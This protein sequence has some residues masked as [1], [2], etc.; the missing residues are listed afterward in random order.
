MQLPTNLA[1]NGAILNMSQ[2]AIPCGLI[3]KSLFNDTFQLYSNITGTG[4]QIT[5]NETNIAW[6]SDKN[7]RY[8]NINLSL[9]WTDMENG[10]MHINNRTLHGLDEN[11]SFTKISKALGQNRLNFTERNLLLS[12]K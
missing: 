2:P 8:K 4:A 3:A 7:G 11:C 1:Y 5:I 12:D 10:R 6:P 9:Q